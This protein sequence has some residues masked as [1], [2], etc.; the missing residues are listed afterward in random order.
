VL[1]ALPLIGFFSK[2]TPIHYAYTFFMLKNDPFSKSDRDKIWCF[3]LSMLVQNGVQ[4]F[5][6]IYNLLDITI[7]P[8]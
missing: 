4:K 2:C 5:H 7:M 1:S 6:P 3:L 8:I